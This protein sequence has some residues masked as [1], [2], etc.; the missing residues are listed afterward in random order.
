MASQIRLYAEYRLLTSPAAHQ[1]KQVLPG[2]KQIPWIPADN[3]ILVL[4]ILRNKPPYIIIQQYIC[5]INN[6]QLP[7]HP[8]YPGSPLSSEPLPF[9]YQMESMHNRCRQ[10]RKP[11]HISTPVHS[12]HIPSCTNFIRIIHYIQHSFAACR[13][14]VNIQ[15]H[16]IKSGLDSKSSNQ[17]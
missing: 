7:F 9:P 6:N 15:C 16:I 2:S 1:L 14:P 12:C 10:N 5:I 3:Q 11:A 8:A 17:F 4:T 13:E